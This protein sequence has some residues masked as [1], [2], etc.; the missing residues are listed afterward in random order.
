MATRVS[1]TS[2]G[3]SLAILIVVCMVDADADGFSV[4]LIHRD[5]S[6][7]PFSN[8]SETQLERVANAM[9]RSIGRVARFTCNMIDVD[10]SDA[11]APLIADYG[12]YLMNISLGMPPYPVLAIADTGSDIIWTQCKPCVNCY[13]PDAPVFDPKLSST[14]RPIPCSSEVCALLADDGSFCSSSRGVCQYRL[15]YEQNSYASGDFARET[16]TLGTTT[17]DVNVAFPNTLFGCGH[18]NT[19]TFSPKSSGIIGLAEGPGSLITQLG[20]TIRGKFSYCMVPHST[21]ANQKTSTMHFGENAVVSGNT[22]T[23]T[24]LF[25]STLPTSFYFLQLNFVSVGRTMIPFSGT[26]FGS[27][28]NI[29]VDSGTP[30]SIVPNDFLTEFANA[31]EVLTIGSNK[32]S[33]PQGVLSLC[34]MIDSNLEVPPITMHFKGGDVELTAANIFVPMSETVTCLAFIGDDD[35]SIYGNLAQQDFLI[36]YDLQK[37]TVSFKPTDC[38]QN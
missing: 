2:L 15:T 14:Y 23:S 21:V 8:P 3:I 6:S 25:S 1:S 5:S 33:D 7:L 30:F 26:S 9:R 19:G 13:K 38:T 27:P 12:E 37:R 35:V 16:L 17:P 4:S 36:G 20:P 28:G 24:P 31:V 32:T 22:V 11:V 34:Y 18:D 10:S 29:I